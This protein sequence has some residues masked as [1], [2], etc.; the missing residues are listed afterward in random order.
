VFTND[1]SGSYQSIYVITHIICNRPTYLK[2]KDKFVLS[3][4]NYTTNKDVSCT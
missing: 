3:L 4:N 1:V 2:G